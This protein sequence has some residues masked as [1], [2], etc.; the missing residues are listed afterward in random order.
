MPKEA[1]ANGTGIQVRIGSKP[2][3]FSRLDFGE[4]SGRLG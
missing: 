4:K 3:E 2:C 1:M